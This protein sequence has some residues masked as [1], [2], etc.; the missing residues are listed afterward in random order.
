MNENE[1]NLEN[2]LRSWRP[3]RPAP[4]IKRRLFP[5][6]DRSELREVWLR[7]LAPAVACVF[8][9]VTIIHQEP[10]LSASSVESRQVA[11]VV[12][13]NLT[14]TAV[15][16]KQH[17]TDQNELSHASFEWTNL[18]DSSSSISPFS[19]GQ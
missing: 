2:Q 16:P 14:Y 18:S 5:L 17:T 1:T 7:C 4:R 12:S 15:F 9:A 11:G 13:S 10:G 19:P 6:A 3:R 8:L